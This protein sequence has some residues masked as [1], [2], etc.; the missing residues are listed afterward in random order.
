MQKRLTR[1]EH[2]KMIAG[3]IAG[4]ANYL[5]HDVVLWRIG[6]VLGLIFTGF[7]PIGV[8]YIAAWVIM[9]SNISQQPE[10]DYDAN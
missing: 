4:I 7:A 10:Y 1:D 8:I 2:N 3:V 5:G 9:P 6:A